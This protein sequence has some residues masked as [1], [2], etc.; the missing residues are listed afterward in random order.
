VTIALFIFW[1][2]AVATFILPRQFGICEPLCPELDQQ[3]E[4]R[5]GAAGRANTFLDAGSGSVNE[6]N[7]LAINSRRA[8]EQLSH[9]EAA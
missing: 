2:M 1:A 4:W 9:R 7:A 8:W 6:H 3:T 5:R